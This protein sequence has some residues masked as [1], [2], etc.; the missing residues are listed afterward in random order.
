MAL[1]GVTAKFAPLA[2]VPSEVPPVGVVYQAMLLPVDV[3]FKFEVALMHTVDGVA[4]AEAG[5]EGSAL[6]D[7][8]DV[9]VLVHP[10][11]LVTV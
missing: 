5:A 7:M 10:Y 8:V 6:T 4:V 9:T 3:A 2:L 1:A 11:A